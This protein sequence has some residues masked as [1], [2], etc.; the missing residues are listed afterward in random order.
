LIANIYNLTTDEVNRVISDINREL[1]Q[2][3]SR[4]SRP[5]EIES[6]LIKDAE[7]GIPSS[8]IVVDALKLEDTEV[9][10]YNMH[11]FNSAACAYSIFYNNDKNATHYHQVSITA[12]HGGA[13]S[14]DQSDN[15]ILTLTAAADDDIIIN[16]MIT[17]QPDELHIYTQGT[18]YR[19][20]DEALGTFYI[21]Y[22]MSSKY[23]YLNKIVLSSSVEKA[24]RKGSHIRFWKAF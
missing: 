4:T 1:K 11:L 15:S 10:G 5:P 6:R 19:E 24:I 23:D 16:G 8:E 17:I 2:I 20:S 14:S 3:P 9:I 21:S 12:I 7:I 13:V 18:I 22:H